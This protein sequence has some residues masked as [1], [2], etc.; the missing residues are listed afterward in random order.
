VYSNGV[1]S[2]NI[3][4]IDGLK[5][6]HVV[7]RVRDQVDVDFFGDDSLGGVVSYVLG[8]R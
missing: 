8:L 3:V 2:A 5:P 7:V 4:L 1:V 6:T